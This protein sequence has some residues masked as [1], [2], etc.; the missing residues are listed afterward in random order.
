MRNIKTFE[1]FEQDLI[2]GGKSDK[3][4]LDDLIKKYGEKYTEILKYNYS[5]GIIVET[6]HTDNEEIANEIALDHLS[7][8]PRYYEILKK[9]GLADEI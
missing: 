2:H 9:S 7:E 3:L 6:E 1:Q 5:L 4:S 8:N